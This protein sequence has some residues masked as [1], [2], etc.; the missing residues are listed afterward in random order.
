MIRV[1]FKAIFLMASCAF[2]TAAYAQGAYRCGNSY[3]QTPCP[4]G[5]AVNTADSRTKEQKAA[6]DAA[7]KRDLRVADSM[8]KT[9]L[10]QEEAQRKAALKTAE[11]PSGKSTASEKLSDKETHSSKKKSRPPEYFTA[12][13]GEKKK[14][15]TEAAAPT[16]KTAANT[17][18]QK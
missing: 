6:A 3:S 13:T 16:D 7:T 10:R 5:V 9:R 2:I 4:G 11:K 15:K 14:K 18:T 1:S 17:G 12:R 8:E